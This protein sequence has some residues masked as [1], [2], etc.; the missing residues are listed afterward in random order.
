MLADIRYALRQLRKAP[1]FTITAV[2]TLA[3]GMGA[4]TAV[5]SL[6]HGALRLPYPAAKRLVTVKNVYPTASYIFDS[7]PDFESWRKE[8]HTFAKMAAIFAFDQK[9]YFSSHAPV[10]LRTP[11]VSQEF[12]SLF[13]L[14]PIAGRVFSANDERKGAAPV[15]VLSESFW[16]KHFGGSRSVLGRSLTLGSTNYMV[17]GVV[18][19]MTPSF[20]RKAQ[21]WLPLGANPPFDQ[22]GENYLTVTG[23]LKP[24]VSLKQA[25]SDLSVIQGRV[26]KVYPGNAHGVALQP[27]S[28][29]FFGDLRPVMLILLAAVGFILLIACV[30]LANMMLARGTE[31]MREFGIRQALGASPLRLLRQSLTESLLL[32]TL[33]GVAGLVLADLLIRIPMG[34]WPSFLEAPRDVPLNGGVLLFSAVLVGATSVLFGAA[35]AIQMLRE[36]AKAAVQRDARTMSESRGQ[37]LVRSGLMVSEIAFATLLVGGALGMTLYF[38]RLLDTNPGVNPSHV[39]S[40]SVA[41]PAG[42]YKT[43]DAKRQFFD[44]LQQKL[45]ALPG[46]TAVGGVNSAPFSGSAG[47]SSY[48]YEGGPPASPTHMVFA[49]YNYV[50]PGYLHAMQ[51]SLLRGRWFAESDDAHGERVA[52]VNEALAHK[53]WPRQTAL[54]KWIKIG[55]GSGKQMVIGVVANIRQS[56]VAQKADDEVYLSAEQY[57]E[58]SLVMLMRTTGDPV[59]LANAARRTVHGI[60]P[61]ALVTAVAPVSTL[62]KKSVAEESTATVLMGMLGVLALLLACVGVYGVIAYTVSRRERE[63]GIRMALGSRRDQI[64]TLLLRSTAKLVAMGFGIGVLLAFPLNGWM[65]S[66]L[67][68]VE[69]FPPI[70][71]AG[72]VILLGVVGLVA[73]AIPA[74]RAASVEPMKAL[75]SE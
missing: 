53:L 37:R 21:V 63:F 36:S 62:A 11:D 34:A 66:L 56:G 51:A 60:A 67:G 45:G 55:A 2:L 44:G 18:P 12:F 15:C 57:P 73:A 28:K 14:K 22:H 1:G 71:M 38:A 25:Q 31:R 8:N 30:N 10:R 50:T 41:L 52:V 24:G 5:F 58:S 6:I 26:N 33:G 54:G 9:A 42:Q 16:K 40:M 29:T 13:G 3:L 23:L 7:Y 49:D 47:S 72:T 74:R 43:D 39:L 4:T 61:G 32:A 65:R 19:E 75:R 59:A 35:P 70:A 20:F 64:V 17:I 48:S 27:L 46:V 69:G 68:N